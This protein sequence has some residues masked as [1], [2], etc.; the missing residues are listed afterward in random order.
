MTNP[1][2]SWLEIASGKAADD[3][4]LEFV[5]INQETGELEEYEVSPSLVKEGL[6]ELTGGITQA[7]LMEKMREHG[8]IVEGEKE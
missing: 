3:E 4:K 2:Y 8:E 5:H 1:V 7:Q 6:Q